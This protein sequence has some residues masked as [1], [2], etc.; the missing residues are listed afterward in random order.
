VAKALPGFLQYKSAEALS[1]RTLESYK[2]QLELWQSYVGDKRVDKVTATDLRA[3]LVWLRDEYRPKRFSKRTTP[4][5]GKTVRLPA[6][7][8]LL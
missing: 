1:P 4:L 5:S 7:K 8:Q 3:F 2:Q 6:L